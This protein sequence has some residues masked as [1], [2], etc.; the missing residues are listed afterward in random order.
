[1]KFLFYIM[2]LIV[3]VIIQTAILPNFS[4]FSQS[5]DLLLVNIIYMSIAFSHPG[6]LL[7]V[8]LQ[9][10]IMDS[11]SGTPFGLY[12]SVYLWVC[13]S[14]QIL[15]RFVHSGNVIF[16][17]VISAISVFVENSFLLLFFFIRYGKNSFY[18]QDIML[19]IKQMTWA[20]FIAPLMILIIHILQKKWNRFV[21]KLNEKKMRNI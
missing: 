9:G 14:I 7:I 19:M 8:V 5:F 2:L 18:P 16:I 13:I 1:M 17:P 6:L 4:F 12:M 3:L 20:F 10:C 21:D 11:I 15:K